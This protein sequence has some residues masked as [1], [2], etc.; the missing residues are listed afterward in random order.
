MGVMEASKIATG[1]EDDLRVELHGTRGAIR[2]DLMH[3]DFVEVFSLSDPGQPLG[4]SRGWKRIPAMNRYPAPGGLPNPRITTG[5]LRSHVHCQYTFLKAVAEGRQPDPSLE[6]GIGV[7]RLMD[8][9]E[10]SAK[11]GHWETV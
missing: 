2:L 10:R 9:A 11:S 8:C 4:G 3:P 5:W 7:Q 1:T 6:R